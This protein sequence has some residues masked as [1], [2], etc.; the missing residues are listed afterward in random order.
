MGCGEKKYASYSICELPMNNVLVGKDVSL[1]RELRVSTR[2][3]YAV[4]PRP[5]RQWRDALS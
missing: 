1:L 5:E 2:C 3:C 4:V